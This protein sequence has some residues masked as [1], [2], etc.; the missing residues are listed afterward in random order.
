MAFLSST[1]EGFVPFARNVLPEMFVLGLFTIVRLVHT[2]LEPG[3]ASLATGAGL[4]RCPMHR[5]LLA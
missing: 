2:A 5:S 4:L 3:S 1:K